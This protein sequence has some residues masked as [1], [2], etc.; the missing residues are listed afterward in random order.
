MIS[1][2]SARPFR[3]YLPSPSI[4]IRSVTPLQADSSHRGQD[5]PALQSRY[6]YADYVD[7]QIWS[8]YQTNTNPLTWSA[9]ELE[10]DT[11]LN[12]SAFGE[13]ERGEL[14]IVDYSGA[15]RRLADVNGPTPQLASSKKQV[16]S[17]SA[18]P[19]EVVTY[20]IHLTNT[21]SLTNR[22]ILLT[23]T[24]P[25][26]LTYVPGSLHASSGTPSDLNSPTLKWSGNL[27]TSHSFTISYQ[28]NVSGVITGSLVNRALVASPPDV[29][30]Q[31]PQA[32]TVPRSS[33]PPRSRISPSLAPSQDILPA[34]SRPQ[35]IAIPATTSQSTTAGAA[36]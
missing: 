27:N 11:S 35:R 1:A 16:S 14:Y 10:L 25:A 34:T 31:L 24:I 23:D 6:F 26:G 15:V 33:S 32:L 13:D 36:A 22:P 20:T 18:N 29:S 5:F 3:S 17:P 7:G 21:G 12:F 2:P 8:L 30:I 19:G 28:V 9:P 4:R